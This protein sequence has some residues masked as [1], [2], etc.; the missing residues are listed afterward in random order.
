MGILSEF[1]ITGNTQTGNLMQWQINYPLPFKTP[2]YMAV[3][4]GRNGIDYRN[5]DC[6]I[7]YEGSGILAGENGVYVINDGQSMSGTGS[8][9]YEG[10]GWSGTSINTNINIITIGFS[11]RH[12]Q[13]YDQ[14]YRLVV[15]ER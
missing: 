15:I 6:L 4:L 13:K 5:N 8:R 12:A 9:I 14:S 2:Y 1:V 7:F 11:V 10:S 3:T